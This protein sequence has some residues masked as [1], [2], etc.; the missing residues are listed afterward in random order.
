MLVGFLRDCHGISSHACYGFWDQ[1]FGQNPPTWQEILLYGGRHVLKARRRVQ[2]PTQYEYQL[3][4]KNDPDFDRMY[5][6]FLAAETHPEHF[7]DVDLTAGLTVPSVSRLTV[8]IDRI[9]QYHDN[10]AC[11]QGKKIALTTQITNL[12]I[13]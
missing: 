5:D 6:N 9:R 4:S 10:G 2:D 7:P 11:P 13:C 8:L 12:L 1:L 3:T